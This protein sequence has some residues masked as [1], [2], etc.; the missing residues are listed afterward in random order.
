MM[1]S[2]A[3]SAPKPIYPSFRHV[4]IDSTVDVETRIS[5]EGKVIG[6]RAIN[7]P[8]DV[9]GAAMQAVQTWRFKPFTLDG[10][11]VAVVTTF[12]FVFKGR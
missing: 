3:I 12:K 10:T 7:G 1:M 4:P 8:I 11:P 9:R 2:Y 5:K 6:V